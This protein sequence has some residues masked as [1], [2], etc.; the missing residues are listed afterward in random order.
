VELSAIERNWVHSHEEDT[1]T[2]KV[3]RPADYAFPLS[4]GR[5]AFDLRPDGTVEE[6][7]PGPADAAEH[8]QGEWRVDGDLLVLRVGDEVQT[9]QIVS[10]DDDRLVVRGPV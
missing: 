4:R 6:S 1:P 9:L 2:E 8:R 7:G 5:D 10:V 3:F